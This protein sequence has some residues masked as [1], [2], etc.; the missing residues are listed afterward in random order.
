MLDTCDRLGGSDTIGIVGEGNVIK[1]FQLPALFPCK[2]VTQ[3][4]KRIALLIPVY[5]YSPW[6]SNLENS[7][8][9]KGAAAVEMLFAKWLGSFIRLIN[10]L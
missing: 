3:V 4:I 2:P 10:S 6:M 5:N 1:G 7:R 9:P 8:T